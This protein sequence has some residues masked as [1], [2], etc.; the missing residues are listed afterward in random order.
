M[1]N[2]KRKD[3]ASQLQPPTTLPTLDE[4]EDQNQLEKE[5]P[6]QLSGHETAMSS[7]KR[8][9]SSRPA[10]PLPALDEQE[11]DQDQLEKELPELSGHE[12]AMSNQKRTQS[13]RPATPLPVLD[14]QEDDQ[15]QL[16]KEL[17]EL[18]GHDNWEE[19]LEKIYNFFGEV[20][21]LDV[22]DG[23]ETLDSCTDDDER[24]YFE[25]RHA[26]SKQVIS[27][28]VKDELKNEVGINL[29]DGPGRMMVKLARKY[30]PVH[31]EVDGFSW[32]K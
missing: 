2:Q 28:K 16:E 20:D 13:S 9:Q 7:Q 32:L 19:W 29:D 4:Q 8:T 12:T 24:G 23:G 15:D 17:P 10:T 26:K 22:V 27:E 6:D 3:Q 5:L 18:S 25:E 11:G 14:E 31:V 21:C 1:S 30:S